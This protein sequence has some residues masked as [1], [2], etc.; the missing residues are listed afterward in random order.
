MSG[1]SKVVR[2]EAFRWAGVELREYKSG[3]AGFRGINRQTL[4]GDGRDEDVL[5]FVTRYFEIQPG[6]YSSLE[7]H[8]HPHS[9]IVLRGTGRVLLGDETHEIAPFDGV[10]VAPGTPHQFQ[11]T[12]DGPLGFLCVV[13]RLRDRPQVVSRREANNADGLP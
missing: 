9:V 7:R 2:S 5:N 12:G 1:S 3:D 11:A 8:E 13:D 4:L 6:G 10:Y